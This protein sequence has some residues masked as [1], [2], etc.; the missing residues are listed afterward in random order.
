MVLLAPP[1]LLSLQRRRDP[2]DTLVDGA[3]ASFGPSHHHRA[4]EAGMELAKRVSRAAT[5]GTFLGYFDFRD[6]GRARPCRRAIG[7]ARAPTSPISCAREGSGCHLHRAADLE[8]TAHTELIRQLRDTTASIYFVPANIFEFDLVQPRCV[9]IHGIP[10]LAI[11]ETPHRGM[12]A[13]AQAGRRHRIRARGA[14]AG[15]TLMLGIAIAVKL[16]SR[17]PILFKQRRYGLNGEEIFIYKFRSMTVCEDG[18][19]VIQAKRKDI[20]TTRVGKISRR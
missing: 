13:S 9:E 10:A 18:P 15:R 3:A 11:C 2:A 1:A 5:A 6:R 8:H 19:S 20:R 14:A 4:T 17:G 16:N 12:S 7:S